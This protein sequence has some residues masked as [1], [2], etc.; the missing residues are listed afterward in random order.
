MTCRMLF[1]TIQKPWWGHL[2][3][4]YVSMY[5]AY[6][7]HLS[8]TALSMILQVWKTETSVGIAPPVR[9]KSLLASGEQCS[10]NETNL[11]SFK[12]APVHKAF[13]HMFFMQLR[14]I[15]LLCKAVSQDVSQRSA[16]S[17]KQDGPSCLFWCLVWENHQLQWDPGSLTVFFAPDLPDVESLKAQGQ[18]LHCQTMQTRQAPFS[19]MHLCLNDFNLNEFNAFNE[20]EAIDEILC[21]YWNQCV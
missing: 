12:H 3:C 9:K 5:F 15:F 18:K 8:W 14:Q 10:T 16:R 7:Q 13:G 2:Q 11:M 20:F 1:G 17:A 4:E 19:F 6:I 21:I